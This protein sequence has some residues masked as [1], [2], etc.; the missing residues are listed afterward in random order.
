MRLR[1]L[2]G[3]V[4]DATLIFITLAGGSKSNGLLFTMQGRGLMNRTA[5]PFL[6]AT[7]AAG[8]WLRRRPS[9]MAGRMLT[10]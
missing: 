3:A 10:H 9:R 8:A 4:A 1:V 6:L 5:V 2:I 7:G